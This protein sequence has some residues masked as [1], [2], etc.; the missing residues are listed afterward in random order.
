MI[1]FCKKCQSDTERNAR[2][3]CKPCAKAYGAAWRADNPERKKTLRAA[4]EKA[5]PKRHKASQAAWREANPEKVKA[6]RAA[7]RAANP[8]K[9]R[10]GKEAYYAANT[11][12]VKSNVTAWAAAN[13]EAKRIYN[14]TRRARKRENGGVLSRG[15][16]AKL[17]KLQRGKCPCCKEPLGEDFH[18]DH[19]MPLALG[20]INTDGNI[21]LLRARCNLQ[22]NAKDPVQ[23]MQQRGFLI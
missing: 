15:L 17:F 11:G 4:W 2:G 19:I 16:A 14:Q 10:A 20:G 3:D 21:Q 1:K 23:F 7:W 6:N 8:E 18:L 12:R 13:P 9:V 5:N 22:K